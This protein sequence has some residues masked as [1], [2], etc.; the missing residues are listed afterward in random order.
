MLAVQCTQVLKIKTL[1]RTVP[2]ALKYLG[3][4]S[5]WEQ[6]LDLGQLKHDT[7][8]FTGLIKLSSMLELFIVTQQQPY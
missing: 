5:Y 6:K 7:H 2:V 3:F 1:S 4:A 8:S